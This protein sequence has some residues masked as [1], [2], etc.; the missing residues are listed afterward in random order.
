MAGG[1]LFMLTISLNE[2]HRSSAEDRKM[3]GGSVPT[4][5]ANWDS[6]S[7]GQVVQLRFQR[8]ESGNKIRILRVALDE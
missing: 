4:D 2:P 1:E 3:L 6:V 7:E 5:K 8:L